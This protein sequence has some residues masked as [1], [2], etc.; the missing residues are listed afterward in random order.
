MSTTS[1]A[2]PAATP[3]TKARRRRTSPSRLSF[4]RRW[5]SP[6]VIVAVWQLLCSAGVL[7]EDTIASPA[8]IADGTL[9][10]AIL[11][12]LQ[13][14]GLGFLIGASVGLVVA[15]AAG[16]SRLGEDAL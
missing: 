5:V 1:L 10:A 13:R 16:L 3:P 4:L 11:A 12:S 15:V 6:I 8:Q 7:T 9:Q 14:V 2:A